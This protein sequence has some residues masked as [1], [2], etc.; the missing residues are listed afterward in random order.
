[1]VAC[2]SHIHDYGFAI[3]RGAVSGIYIYP[4]KSCRSIPLDSVTVSSIGLSGDRTW[5][6]IDEDGRG[7]TQRQHRVLATVQPKI[8][9]QGMQLSSPGMPSIMVGDLGKPTMTAQSHFGIPVAVADAGEEAAGWFSQ[10]LD[11]SY[12]LVAMRPDSG[13]RLPSDLDVFG[14]NAGFTDAA[15]LLLA[16]ESSHAWLSER[17]SEEFGIDRFQANIVVRD[18]E[19]WE[20]DTWAEFSLGEATLNAVVPWPRCAIPQIDQVTS[21][22]HR[23]PAKVLRGHRWCTDA[24]AIGGKFAELVAGNGLFGV[25]CSVGPSAARIRVGDEVEV[26]SGENVH[27][28]EVALSLPQPLWSED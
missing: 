23:E 16:S 5:Q 2:R 15:P 27:R 14:Q 1:M 13:W 12:R 22:R 7:V 28:I 6:V 10:M 21:A 9:V 4:I 8:L 11:G 19:P 25:G 18:T 20:E 24:S 17:A 26:R 3:M